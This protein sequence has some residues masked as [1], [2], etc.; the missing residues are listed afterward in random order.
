MIV[1]M[2]E[3]ATVVIGKMRGFIGLPLRIEVVNNDVLGPTPTMVSAWTPTPAE[4][5]ALNAGANIHVR[6]YGECHPPIMVSVGRPPGVE[7]FQG[8]PV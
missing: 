6:L 5:E 7:V 3:G 8:A 1:A 4:L 2:I